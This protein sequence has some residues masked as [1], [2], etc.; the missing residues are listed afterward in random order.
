MKITCTRAK[1]ARLVALSSG[2][3]ILTGL[4]VA[5]GQTQNGPGARPGSS[6]LYDSSPET[7][8]SQTAASEPASPPPSYSSTQN[9]FLS[10]V[11]EGKATGTVLPLSFKEAIDRALRNNLGLLLS[12]DSSMAARGKKWEE[13]S[14]LLPN[15]S[16]SANQSAQQ[17]DLAALG[18]RFNFPGV[19]P[20]IGPIGTFDARVY[21]S[22]PIFDW[23]SIERERGARASETA[24]RYKYNDAREMVV[25]A[26]G[27]EYLVTLS[28][29]ARVDA[30]QAELETAQALFNK[31]H[32]QQTAGVTPAIDTLRAQVEFQTRQQQLIVARNNYAK[33]KLALAR[34]IG[35]PPGQEFNLTDQAPYKPLTPMTVEQAL[36]RA[37]LARPDYQAVAQ[38]VRSAEQFRRAATAEH[39]P[40]LDISGNYGAAGVNVGDSH[41][42]FLAGATLAIPIFAGGRAHADALQAEATL[43][44]SRQQLESLRAQID[45][46]VRS[47]LL[48]LSA[49]NDQV[50][51]ARS[52]LDLAN[53][54]LVQ[55]RDRFTAGVADNLEVIEAQDAVASANENYIGS[56]YAH[57][58]AKVLLARAIG[59]AEQGVKQYLEGR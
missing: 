22:A 52:A 44:Q 18:F 32:D 24:A 48:D 42:V 10:S 29:A 31:A 14:K 26:T 38:E 12:S 57:N 28:A 27:N 4:T 54:T 34:T 16:A 21:L 6:G 53:Q 39:L 35:L 20:V 47:A 19:P 59:F 2:L 58:V 30:A 43:K 51:V 46:D 13:L 40:T 1:S 25:L 50:Q 33:Q 9:P 41:G 23:H 56:L 17:I 15:I 37:Y 7:S 3:L 55:A 36:Q 8:T 5:F 49:A 11:P 45:Y